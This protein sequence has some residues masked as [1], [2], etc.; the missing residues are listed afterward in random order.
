MLT[1]AGIAYGF[2][3]LVH[4]L[5][6]YLLC[7]N[8]RE[9]GFARWLLLAGGFSVIWSLVEVLAISYPDSLWSLLSPWFEI[10]RDLTWLFCLYCLLVPLR[11]ERLLANANHRSLFW[12]ASTLLVVSQVAVCLSPR[13]EL[14]P[15]LGRLVWS[16]VGLLW[17][18]WLYR[19]ARPEQRWAVK[20][21]CLG[22]ALIFGYDFY[23]YSDAL[24]FR[25]VSPDA[26]AVRG[27]LAIFWIPMI[28]LG[29]ARNRNWSS[30]LFI[31]RRATMHSV[32]LGAVSAYLLMVSA[33]GYYVR[34][35]GGDWG[36]A[37]L[38]LLTFFAV[39][40]LLLLFISGNVRSRAKVFFQKNFLAYKYDYRDEWIRFIATLSRPESSGGWQE[41]SIRALA[42]MVDSQGGS[43]WF[44][45]EQGILRCQEQWRMGVPEL[46]QLDANSTLV[47]FLAKTE[48]VIELPEY[49]ASPHSYEGLELPAWL[50]NLTNPWLIVP[51]MQLEQL[52]GFILLAEPKVRREINWEDHDLLK[53]A[54][55]QLAHYVALSQATE[56]LIE[57][58]QFEAFNRMS[59][60]LVHDLKN[61]VA[62][63]A[64]VVSNSKYH[65]RNPEFVDDAI[66][67]VDNAVQKMQRV[68]GQLRRQH[69]LE[70]SLRPLKLQDIYQS[71]QAHFAHQPLTLEFAVMPEDLSVLAEREA[72]LTVLVHLVQNGLEASESPAQIDILADAQRSEVR[73]RVIDY[74]CGMDELFIR[75]RLFKPFDS[76]K[77]KAGMGI[78]AYQSRTLIEQQEGRLQVE[79]TP[80]KGT[81]FTLFLMRAQ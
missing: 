52:N 21:L 37:F 2:S 74:G 78:G 35:N 28:A 47:Q 81:T 39:V 3:A 59:A 19:Q 8:W 10:G 29:V 61:V 36:S 26:Y 24:M 46:C 22:L 20:F 50:L 63:L 38:V 62:Q 65:K 69:K 17:L 42:K 51:L 58:R 12:L 34:L 53:T 72:L 14:L 5:F 64:M 13:Y 9:R 15:Y 55:R 33:A 4:L 43:L 76:T 57:A 18:E 68:L 70:Q 66:E 67:T 75:E 23:L 56:A 48:W 77:G 79:S 54:G 30:G 49:R 27:L 80:G 41:R 11:E 44:F 45:D 73:I 40:I 1:L 6:A 25:R 32:T 60:F 31:S 71:L 16:I 7:T